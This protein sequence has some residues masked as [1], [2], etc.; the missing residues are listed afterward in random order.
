[1]SAAETSRHAHV[2]SP[3][4]GCKRLH[5]FIG[6]RLRPC[7]LIK[8]LF[9]FACHRKGMEEFSIIVCAGPQ[10]ILL[11]LKLSTSMTQSLQLLLATSHPGRFISALLMPPSSI[12]L[13]CMPPGSTSLGAMRMEACV[14]LLPSNKHVSQHCPSCTPAV[15]ICWFMAVHRSWT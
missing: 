4:V 3:P 15:C 13:W 5:H 1:M 9:T 10:G 2:Y 12:C 11:H 6:C 7:M 8:R 14:K